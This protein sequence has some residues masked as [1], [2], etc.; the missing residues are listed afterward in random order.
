MMEYVRSRGFMRRLARGALGLWAELQAPI[1]DRA[2]G[3]EF[4][5]ARCTAL[6]R[7]ALPIERSC[8]RVPL[9]LRRHAKGEIA[10]RLSDDPD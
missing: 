5:V 8:E 7:R 6:V 9:G 10:Q 3:E 2:E 4:L 1:P